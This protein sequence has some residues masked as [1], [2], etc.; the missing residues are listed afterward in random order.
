MT[1]RRRD[2]LRGAAA[3][4]GAGALAAVGGTAAAVVPEAAPADASGPAHASA[5]PRV[6]VSTDIGGSDPDDFQS[7]V[8]LLLSA[9]RLDLEGL[10]SSPWGAGRASD[11]L[12]VIAEYEKDF[13]NLRTYSPEYPTPAA[14]RA[15]TKQGALDLA[16]GPT[17]LGRPTEGS[18]WIVRCARSRDRRPLHVLVWGGIEDLAQALHDAPDIVDRIKVFYIGGP[19]KL[20]SVNAYNYVETKH[21]RLWMIESNSAYRGFFTGGDQTGEWAN[22]SFITTHVAGHGALGAFFATQLGGVKMGDTPS[23]VR[24]FN[25]NGNPLYPSWGGRYVPIWDGRKSAFDRLTTEDDL[26]EA[27]GVI[28]WT[29]RAPRGYSSKDSTRFVVDNRTG[30]PFPDGVLDGNRL[31]FRYS[32]RDPRTMPIRVESTHPDL[33]GL[34]GAFTATAPPAG[35]WTVPSRTHPR[36]FAD[37][38]DPI[39]AEGLWQGAKSVSQWRVEYLRDFA[40]LLDRCLGPKA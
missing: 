22:D 27:Y 38:Q 40:T 37:D 28:E 25:G 11:I 2:F 12:T 5:R 39:Y 23:V 29:L 35:R 7:M 34:Q 8:H 14:L 9:H 15:I 4:T 19:N 21:P 30:G 26:V 32:P 10:V 18:K 24:L 13:P 36:W 33:N 3:V 20:W 1:F 16:T 31:R 6:L 17:G